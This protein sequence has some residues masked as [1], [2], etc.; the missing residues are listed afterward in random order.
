MDFNI[1]ESLFGSNELLVLLVEVEISCVVVI[2]GVAS[3]F[4]FH[5]FVIYK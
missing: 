3:D 5:R 1:A 2:G 4:I